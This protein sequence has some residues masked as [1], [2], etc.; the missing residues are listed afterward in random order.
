MLRYGFEKLSFQRIEASTD[1][2][3][4]ASSRVMEKV[5]MSFWKRETTNG[6]DTIYYAIS[7]QEFNRTI[8]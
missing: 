4:E 7:R 3:N 2:A 1:A 6:L 8:L 5:R